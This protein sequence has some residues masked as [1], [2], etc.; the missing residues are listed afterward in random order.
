MKICYLIQDFS[1][2]GSTTVVYDLINNA[3]ASDTIFL[4]LFFDIFDPRY[5]SIKNK[6]N[7]QIIFLHKTKTVDFKFLKS[8]KKTIN[9]IRPDIISCHLSCVFYL[10]LVYDFKKSIVFHTIHN[11]PKKDLPFIY[12]LFLRKK[13]RNRDI[14]LISCGESVKEEAEKYYKVPVYNIQNGIDIS[15]S[16]QT[17]NN[18]FDEVTFLS[19]GR[20]TKVKSVDNVVK[21]FDLAHKKTGRGKLI[22]CGYG[23]EEDSLKTLVNDRNLSSCVSILGKTNDV[24]RYY[25]QSQVFCLLSE[26][27]GS[28]IVLLESMKYGLCA[29][30]SNVQGTRDLI[31]DGQ[32]GFLVDYNDVNGAAEKMILFIND[33]NKLLKMRES[34]LKNVTNFDLTKMVKTYYNLFAVRL[35]EKLK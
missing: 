1:L 2:G 29:I 26:R 33:R 13:I 4:L 7:V 22:I 35:K 15:N 16:V 24:E 14:E 31:I 11:R 18:T 34:S 12:R 21:A 17:I 9:D 10:S 32:T 6:K 19:I 5:S 3:P 27:E 20:L 23:P 30:G 25:R 28:P 8:L